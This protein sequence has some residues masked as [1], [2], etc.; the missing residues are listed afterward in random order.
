MINVGKEASY[1]RIKGTVDFS[2]NEVMTI[3]EDLN[4]PLSH[5]TNNKFEYIPFTPYLIKNSPSEDYRSNLGRVIEDFKNIVQDGGANAFFCYDS[6]PPELMFPFH[7]IMKMR[8]AK[9]IHQNNVKNPILI[10]DIEIPSNVLKTF[11]NFN[12]VIEE[13]EI[14]LIIGEYILRTSFEEIKYFASLK[15]FS[16]EFL[17]KLEEEFNQFLDQLESYALTGKSPVG[18][19]FDIYLYHVYSTGS[20]VLAQSTNRN[21]SYLK[22]FGTNYF[23]SEDPSVYEAQINWIQSMKRNSTYITQ[24][25]ELARSIFFRTQRGLL[26]ECIEYSL[27]FIS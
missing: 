14:T 27:S 21:I 12:S 22:S 6:I 1:R 9:Y 18:K 5:L 15:L 19:R 17:Y 25:G 8:W 7:N 16:I 13:F 26:K 11:D 3:I 4:I 2:F 24:S 23:S 20:I 10:D